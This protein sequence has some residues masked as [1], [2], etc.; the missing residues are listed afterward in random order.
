MYSCFPV[1]VFILTFLNKYAVLPLYV[2]RYFDSFIEG[3]VEHLIE[4]HT[5]AFQVIEESQVKEI[6]DV[7]KMYDR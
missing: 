2:C 5:F 4:R 3:N 6:R 1:L 7:K